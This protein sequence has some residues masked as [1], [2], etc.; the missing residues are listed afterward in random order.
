M[1]IHLETPIASEV[2]SWRQRQEAPALGTGDLHLWRIS[3]SAPGENGD[4]ALAAALALLDPSQRLRAQRLTRQ[5]ARA[6]YVR[7]QAALRRIL[8]LY[9]EGTRP[10]S[11]VFRYGPAGKPALEDAPPD[12]EFNLTTTGDLALLGISLGDAVGVDCERIRPRT[13]LVAIARRMFAPAQAE[14]IATLPEDAALV[15]FYRCWTAM[16]AD[17]K[18]DGRGLFRPR[19]PGAQPPEIRHCVPAPGYVAAVARA[20]VPPL[21]AWQMLELAT[22]TGV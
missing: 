19:P 21:R 18:S 9:L 11:L 1:P 8:S 12:F 4:Q 20:R 14:A 22:G 6:R 10:A 3:T 17:A 7:A 5:T 2:M 15:S 13:G 16:E